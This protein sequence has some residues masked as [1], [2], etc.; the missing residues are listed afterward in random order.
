MCVQW[1]CWEKQVLRSAQ[2]DKVESATAPGKA[3]AVVTSVNEPT[4]RFYE[5]LGSPEQEER[6]LIRTIP[7]PSNMRC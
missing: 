1:R 5:H 7:P 3:A 2:N 4:I 6:N